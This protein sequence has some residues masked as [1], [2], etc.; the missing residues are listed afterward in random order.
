[1]TWCRFEEE[2]ND[3]ELQIDQLEELNNEKNPECL[4]DKK[5]PL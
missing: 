2:V 4:Q 3:R 1:M 5:G